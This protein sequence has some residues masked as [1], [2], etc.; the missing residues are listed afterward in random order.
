MG[1]AIAN[2]AWPVALLAAIVMI[3][4]GVVLLAW[5]HATLAVVAILIGAALVVAGVFKLFEGITGAGEG[6]GMRAADI[7]IGLLAIVAGLYCL[8][9]HALTVLT[10]VVVVGVLWVIHGISDLIT[11]ATMG[12]VPGRGLKVLTGVVGLAA[13]LVILFWPSISLI[14]LLTVLAAWLLFY[15]LMLAFLS[16]SLARDSRKLSRAAQPAAA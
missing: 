8:K 12:K 6:A 5:P 3:G 11:A 2:I 1:A 10:V 16:F 9:H 4:L 13:G 14:L 7:V 15:G